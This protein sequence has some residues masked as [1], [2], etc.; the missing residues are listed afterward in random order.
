MLTAPHPPPRSSESAANRASRRQLTPGLSQRYRAIVQDPQYS[1]FTRIPERIVRYLDSFQIN[2]DR[3]L[4][5]ERLLAHY[6]F[7]A[8]VDDAIDS[9][10]PGVVQTVFAC[11]DDDNSVGS[12]TGCTS[13][14]TI[15]AEMLKRHI[16]PEAFAL[17]LDAMRR[18]HR[19]VVSER[20]AVSIGAYMKHRKALGRATAKQSY[21]LIQSEFTEPNQE[22]CHLMQDIGAVGCLIDS[23]IDIRHDSRSGLLNFSLTIS[24]YAKLCC[25]TVVE[26]LR[27]WAKKPSLSFLLIEAILD[28]IRDRTRARVS[29][30]TIPIVIEQKDEAARVA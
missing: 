7:I 5:H 29:D 14:I 10:E 30:T 26:G 27:V 17:M 25:S 28:N 12:E 16:D 21:L 15:V 18:A 19:E 6:I 11:L 4:V 23:V 13:K 1:H 2:F 22:L 24:D 8:V 20:A 9:G 3:E